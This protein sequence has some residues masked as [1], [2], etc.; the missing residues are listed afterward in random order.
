MDAPL[1]TWIV[2]DWHLWLQAQLK[3]THKMSFIWYL[4]LNQW[5]SDWTTMM[6]AISPFHVNQAIDAWTYRQP[7]PQGFP[8]MIPSGI[9]T[10]CDQ[11]HSLDDWCVYVPFEVL[12]VTTWTFQ[13]GLG[14]ICSIRARGHLVG[15]D[16]CTSPLT[17][18][19]TPTL[20][21]GDERLHLANCRRL[22]KYPA[23]NVA[24][25]Y[26]LQLGGYASV[27]MTRWASMFQTG[28]A[29]LPRIF[30]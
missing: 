10:L 18:T 1:G 20:M 9:I 13:S 11:R 23:T 27:T 24:I 26:V 15:W 3:Y 17:H 2:V 22:I 28:Q 7:K 8:S 14:W 21:F 6:C 12:R 29:M 4:N 16:T 25:G 5:K 19:M 30:W